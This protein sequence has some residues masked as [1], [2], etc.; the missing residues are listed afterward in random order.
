LAGF[1][2]REAHPTVRQGADLPKQVPLRQPFRGVRLQESQHGG[3]QALLL[4]L[5]STAQG[6]VQANRTLPN[7]QSDCFHIQQLCHVNA[8]RKRF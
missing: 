8:K 3:I 5:R 2:K 1:L 7:G 6:G 4:A